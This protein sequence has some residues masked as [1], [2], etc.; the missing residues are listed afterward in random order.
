MKKRFTAENAKNAERRREEN[1]EMFFTPEHAEW[2]EGEKAKKWGQKDDRTWLKKS[3]P[4]S[5]FFA[6]SAVNFFASIFLPLHR[7]RVNS[8]SFVVSLILR[9]SLRSL[10]LCGFLL[11]VLLARVS[12]AADTDTS[13]PPVTQ[14]SRPW[15]YWWWMGSAVDK[16]NITRQ[17]EQFHDAGQGGVHI[18][19]IYGAK[20][21]EEK[22]IPYLG[23]KWMEML[24]HTVSEAKRLD[25]GV[26]MTTG[27]GWC[28]GGPNVS[29]QDANAS[30]VV[31]TF[32]VPEG[33]KLEE[34]LDSKTIQALVAFSVDGKYEDLTTKPDWVAKGGPWKVYAIFQ[35]PSSQKVK[36]PAPGGEGYMLNLIYPQAMNDFLVRFTEAFAS[37]KGPLPR[38]QYH[39]SY[40]YKSD[41]AP[42]FFAQFEKRRGY[43]LQTELPALVA[44]KSDAGGRV[45]CDYRETV[46]DV[47]VEASLPEWV[48]WSH[49]HR[50][51]T[52][53][54]AHGSP[55][56]LLDLYAVADIPETEMFNQ[57]RSK[58]ISKFASSAAHVTGRTLVSAETGTWLKEHFTETL[59]DVKYL[60]D[61]MFLS[62]VNHIFYHGNC[63]SP[64][65]A[66][67][68]GWV[69]YA[70]TEMNPR[71]SIW[72]DASAVN[73]YAARCQSILQSGEA[74]N[75]ILLYW[76]IHDFWSR[77]ET[78]NPNDETQKKS[79]ARMPN[80]ASL[81][82]HLT[83]HARL[84]FEDQPIG[85]AA[86]RLWNRGFTFD[87]ISD[88]Q[89][90]NARVVKGEIEMQ[91][92]KERAG[93]PVP[94]V[95]RYRV[96]VVP[97]CER[98][99]VGT[100]EKLLGLADGGAT[101]IFEASVPKDVPGLADLEKRRAK[102]KELI[103]RIETR[104]QAAASAIQV[105]P[106]GQGKVLV[107]DI[108]SCLSSAHVSRESLVE[109]GLSFIRR[110][111]DN[112]T[113]YFI[114]NRSEKQF[115]GWLPLNR[116]ANSVLLMDPLSGNSGLGGLKTTRT[117]SQVFVQ[118]R[119]GES[120]IARTFS[121]QKAD[122]A[123]WTYWQSKETAASTINGNW[124]IEFISGGPTL[125]SS[126]HTT[127][128]ISWN[129]LGGEGAQAFAG[130][131]RYTVTFDTPPGPGKAQSWRLSLGR[132]CQSARVRLNGKDLGTLIIPPFQIAT[133]A[134]KPKDNV[135]EIEVT[136]T[137]ANR[138][139]DLD[140]R[141]VNWKNFRDIN[142]VNLNYKPFDASSWPLA[143]SGLLGPVT[144]TPLQPRDMAANAR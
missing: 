78:R 126:L 39:D 138:I 58:L 11:S 80:T 92:V 88:R 140:R 35:K 6:F 141:G 79:E 144:L 111:S 10:P 2:V 34:K 40:E 30:V 89:L 47:M 60:F 4:F 18:I 142:F 70:S 132:V 41:W 5:A 139:R 117:N 7:I 143:D 94:V 56:N 24:D 83:V 61:D 65:E 25:M 96:V 45:R 36:R 103:G 26:D 21:Y 57:D 55:G 119:P 19:P 31:K 108:E 81:L 112:N 72:H 8:C 121:E 44:P 28:F 124:K 136:N 20:G 123:A 91:P 107:G 27:T 122:G 134:L 109:S 16:T 69:F 115:E 74:D 129:S 23:P 22:Y 95:N 130:T 75:D 51:L 120:I 84:W 90:V 137:S 14:A 29:E 54:E 64:E 133:D 66:G 113:T 102:L 98:M 104:S 93:L 17:L 82:P 73:A 12:G 86:L 43:R 99:P 46:S 114:A 49:Q 100:M 127:N 68:P 76:P 85:K 87:Y 116:A 59:A 62:G 32:D 97:K 105:A 101:V 9:V 106:V 67:W 110:R 42:D 128:L 77:D 63:Y 48:T 38:A 1:G 13:W 71:N 33:G 50:F 135:L 125:P 53:N 15:C 52:R 118:L 3:F 131:A 37:Y